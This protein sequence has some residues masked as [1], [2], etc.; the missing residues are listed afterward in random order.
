MSYTANLAALDL[1][2]ISPSSDKQKQDIIN[3]IAQYNSQITIDDAK[4]IL[5]KF[6]GAFK[7]FEPRLKDDP[8]I[9]IPAIVAQASNFKELDPKLQ[10]DPEIS[11]AYYETLQEEQSDDNLP[12]VNSGY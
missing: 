2:S 4:L 9:I 10:K 5:S 7:Y 8:N 11:M 12:G 1:E 3:F 6:G